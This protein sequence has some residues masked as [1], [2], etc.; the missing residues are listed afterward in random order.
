[1]DFSS[2][3]RSRTWFW[4]DLFFTDVCYVSYVCQLLLLPPLLLG[5]HR[6]S[7]DPHHLLL[8]M[9]LLL[10]LPHQGLEGDIQSEDIHSRASC[11]CVCVCVWLHVPQHVYVF[12]HFVC[13]LCLPLVSPPGGLPGS[14]SPGSLGPAASPALSSPHVS[15]SPPDAAGFGRRSAAFHWN[16]THMHANVITSANWKAFAFSVHQ[17]P[18]IRMWISWQE[19]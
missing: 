5:L 13:G 16:E 12:S 7:V 19:C 15:A 18:T 10:P 4:S 1:M 9:L 6:L 2:V 14:F 11:L 8:Q 17:W 3:E